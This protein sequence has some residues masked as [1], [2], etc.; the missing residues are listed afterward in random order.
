M[1]RKLENAR[2]LYLLGIRDGRPREAATQC[3]GD[4]YI[5]HSA[6]VKDGVE[7]FVAFFEPFLARNPVRDIR[8]L[9]SIEDGQYVFVHVYQS[10]NHGESRWVTMD[11]FET[12]AND[13]IVEHWDVITAYVEPTV[14]GHSMTD[15]PSEIA[16]LASTAAN[17]ALVRAFLTEVLGKGELGKIADYLS[18]ERYTQHSLQVADGIGGTVAF[19]RAQ[20]E[21]GSALRYDEIFKVIGQ[22]NF[23]A[24]LSRV[25]I[26]GR[27]MAVFDLFRLAKG[28]IVEHWDAIEEIAPKE[29]WANSGKF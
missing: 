7:G 29:Q 20:A 13:R 1:S 22:G 3:T 28:K 26:G 21:G 11:M 23:V 17:K 15:G 18:P 16:D 8:I 4:R 10:L 2:K 24:S 25:S 27:S 6:G 9:R 19:L 14:S 12:D 5:Q